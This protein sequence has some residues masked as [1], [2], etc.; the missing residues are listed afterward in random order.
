MRILLVAPQFGDINSIPEIRSLT[1]LHSVHV[2]SG[3]VTYSDLLEAAS[4]SRRDIIHFAT[5]SDSQ[6]VQLSDAELT[7]EAVSQVARLCGARLVFFNSCESSRHAAMLVR[8]GVEFAI[9]TTYAIPDALAWQMPFTFYQHL[10]AQEK[11]GNTIDIP[12]AFLSADSGDGSYGLYRTI[13]S[14]AGMSEVVDELKQIK[15][16]LHRRR[17]DIRHLWYALIVN[18]ATLI[19]AIVWILRA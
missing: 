18:W 19:T 11:S 14:Q 12:A 6:R 5:H 13:V 15:D 9:H 1:E 7:P 10:H 4:S 17:R 16:E 2:L 8:N 3:K